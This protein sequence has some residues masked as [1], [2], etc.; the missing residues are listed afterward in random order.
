MR[1]T[2]AIAKA[3]ARWGPRVWISSDTRPYPPIYQV[4]FKEDGIFKPQGT[5]R[6]W[7]MAFQD[8]D[9]KL[10]GPDEKHPCD[11]PSTGHEPGCNIA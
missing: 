4:G 2:D 1:R 6:D 10:A 3:R 5:G 11:C 7:E 8:A 9:N